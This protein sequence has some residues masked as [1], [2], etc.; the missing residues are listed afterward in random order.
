MDALRRQLR[1]IA[2]REMAQDSGHDIA[3]L[4]RVWKNAQHIAAG[5]P[6][7]MK[8]LLAACYLHDLVNMAKDHPDLTKASTQ[9]ARKSEPILAE[10]GF[11]LAEIKA[12]QHAI[13]AHSFSAGIMPKTP[14]AKIL[15][16]ADRIDALGAVGLA[17]C[18]MITGQL[19]RALYDPTD[20]F[21]NARP[22]D[23][24]RFG[25]DHFKTKLL[26]LPEDMLTPKGRALAHKRAQLLQNFL[27]DLADEIGT[28]DGE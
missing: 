24:S 16:D 4:D 13:Q 15:R 20:P 9:S 27:D 5:G 10:L 26:Q 7:D 28:S 14:E 23:D 11:S 3:H 19:G 25:I 17:R 18:L 8:V 22:L 21:A 1:Q 12:A 6:A 2:Q